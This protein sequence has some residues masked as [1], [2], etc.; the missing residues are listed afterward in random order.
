MKYRN[1]SLTNLLNLVSHFILKI[2]LIH[3]PEPVNSNVQIFL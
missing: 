2:V 3:F 1:Y